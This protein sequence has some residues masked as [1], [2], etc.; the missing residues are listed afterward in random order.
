MRWLEAL[1]PLPSPPRKNYISSQGYTQHFITSVDRS[2][3]RWLNETTQGSAKAN[4]PDPP[5]DQSKKSE[6]N[7]DRANHSYHRTSN[8]LFGDFVFVCLFVF[9]F[10]FKHVCPTVPCLRASWIYML[11]CFI[12][13]SGRFVYF[14][15]SQLCFLLLC[16]LGGRWI[17]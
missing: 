15:I 1:Q 4:L 9:N 3:V 12:L 10:F 13:C 5:I 2:K 14:L 7:S 8:I 6:W 16:V 17:F 11:T